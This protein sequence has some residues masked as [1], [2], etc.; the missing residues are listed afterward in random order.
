VN[1]WVPV[2]DERAALVTLAAAGIRVSPGA[3]FTVAPL[4]SDHVRVTTALLR[5]DGVAEVADHLAAVA[6]GPFGTR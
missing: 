4:G 1:L 2:A 3:P 5:E 6:A